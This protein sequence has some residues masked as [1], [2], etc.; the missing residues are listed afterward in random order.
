ML[1][2]S[3]SFLQLYLHKKSNKSEMIEIFQM[4]LSGRRLAQFQGMCFLCFWALCFFTK[5]KFPLSLSFSKKSTNVYGLIYSSS[6][7]QG[8]L[9]QS[10]KYLAG[11]HIN[12][13]WRIH[14]SKINLTQ[15][16][17]VLY[18]VAIKLCILYNLLVVPN[19]PHQRT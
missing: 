12:R 3:C 11:E 7:Q 1:S 8:S 4:H 2:H 19:L 6:H 15:I 5:W 18:N 14:L 13:V 17:C 16:L 9:L 10:W